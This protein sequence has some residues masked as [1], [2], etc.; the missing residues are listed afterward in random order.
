[1]Y[2]KRFFAVR[3]VLSSS[4]GMPPLAV[5]RRTATKERRGGGETRAWRR[6]TTLGPI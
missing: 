1:M 6:L 4:L 2:R 5:M 3:M